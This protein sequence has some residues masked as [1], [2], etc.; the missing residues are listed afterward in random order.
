MYK[1]QTGDITSVGRDL[2]ITTTASLTDRNAPVFILSNF[3]AGAVRL[4][5]YD[6]TGNINPTEAT[7]DTA[8]FI[9]L[10]GT[11]INGRINGTTPGVPSNWSTGIFRV[12]ISS[13]REICL[14]GTTQGQEL[15]I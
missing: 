13:P 8:R 9:D 2:P 4:T 7:V 6:I 11:D 3:P 14:L 12:V 15:Q 10:T 1:R 5:M